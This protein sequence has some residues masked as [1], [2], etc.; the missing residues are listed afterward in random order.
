MNLLFYSA[1]LAAAV[2]CFTIDLQQGN[3][4]AAIWEV[5]AFFWICKAWYHEWRNASR[6]SQSST[7]FKR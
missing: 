3:T 2:A 6:Y 5:A 7:G 4:H 1:W